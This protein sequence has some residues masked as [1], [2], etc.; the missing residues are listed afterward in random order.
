M[1]ESDLQKKLERLGRLLVEEI[2]GWESS[3]RDSRRE[4]MKRVSARVERELSHAF[5]SGEQRRT[6]RREERRRRK[7]DARR[8]E[9]EKASGLGG[10]VMLIIAMACL[11]FAFVQPEMWWL[12]FVA[13]GLGVSGAQQI[14]LASQKKS[15]ASGTR[16]AEAESAQD[17]PETF[18]GRHEVD[19]LCD[20]LLHELKNGPEVVRTF[21]QNPEETVAS[22]RTT[23]KALD[24]RRRQLLAENP[25]E[26]RAELEKRREELIQKRTATND[27][28]AKMKLDQALASLQT[29]AA[30][31]EQLEATFQRID[32]EY[33]G[34]LVMLEELRTRMSVARAAG[35][36]LQIDA[37]R[38][39]VSK[40]NAELE[41]IAEAVQSAPREGLPRME[42]I[43][44]VTGPDTSASTGKTRER[45]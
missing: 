29:Q 1:A 32:G 8:R 11:A 24:E 2:E 6:R 45:V 3:T 33:T 27:A 4:A 28:V 35:S 42:P 44:D 31:I 36:P 21:L 40:L 18:L 13:L 20:R 10:A 7:E 38:E 16:A 43:A 26:K 12:V 17:V 19:V 23:C 22:L 14:T 39:N 37:L 25:A 30:A 5:E 41:A 34:L 9:I 15:L